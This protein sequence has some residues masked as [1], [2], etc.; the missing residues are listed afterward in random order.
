[1]RCSR[2]TS[3]AAIACSLALIGCAGGLSSPE[4][5]AYLGAPPDGG[6]APSD[7]DGGC[8]PVTDIFPPNCTT[9][10]CHSAATKQANLDLE[11]AGLPQRLLNAPAHGGPGLL[12]DKANPLQSVLYT[13]VT[14][15]P[16]F[17]F[18]MP[19]SGAL[20]ADE[21]SCLRDWITAA[22]R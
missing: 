3:R 8:D 12:I 6:S 13:K 15:T 22:A 21:I 18:Q 5:F 11:S 20:S 19:L 14:D 9:S 7:S 4:R 16:P 2:S 10:A 17:G 1:M